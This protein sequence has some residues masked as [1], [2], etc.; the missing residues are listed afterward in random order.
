MAP[1]SRRSQRRRAKL[2][3]RLIL[4]RD[5]SAKLRAHGVELDEPVSV[6]RENPLIKVQA[7]G[8]ARD[9]AG[10]WKWRPRRLKMIGPSRRG[11]FLTIILELADD[12]GRSIVV[13]GYP[14]GEGDL[15]E[16]RR[17]R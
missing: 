12:E 15:D 3:R 6:L 13:T 2:P 14:A 9:D 1:R 16:Y 8:Y 7:S 5:T 10:Q 11:R 4:S 17:S